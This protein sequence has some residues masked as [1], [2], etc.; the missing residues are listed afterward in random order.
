MKSLAVAVT[1]QMQA[2][3][4]RPVVL[5]EIGLSQTTLYYVADRVGITF[6]GIYYTPKAITLS[7]IGQS[8]EGQINRIDLNFD[9][10]NR[11][12]SAYA[13]YSTFD[14]KPLIIK[15][16]YRDAVSGTTHYNE[17]FHGT[18]EEIGNIASIWFPITASSGKAL[19]QRALLSEYQR[20]CRYIFGDVNCNISG[21]SDLTSASNYAKGQVLS[22]GTGHFI[23]NTA[24]GSVTGTNNDI[25][26]Y[27]TIKVGLSGT[28]Y[29]RTCTAWTSAT[30]KATWRVG[31]P[32][33]I[34]NSYAYEIYKGCPK[35][36]DAC[37]AAFAF[38][39]ISDNRINFGGFLH[40]GQDK[41]DKT[42]LS[43]K[44]ETPQIYTPPIVPR[45]DSGGSDDGP[46]DSGLISD[47]ERAESQDPGPNV[48]DVEQSDSDFGGYGG[49][50]DDRENVGM[51]TGTDTDHDPGMDSEGRDSG[52][53]GMG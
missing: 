2:Q 40:I 32:V 37:T 34:D 44:A 20:S 11:D 50:G 48:H 25:F 13:Q 5:F 10:V 15:R 45:D 33:S 29:N 23:I 8:S 30:S 43:G 38:G 21:F 7:S 1:T 42:E 6:A 4:K 18:M 24:V 36:L 14:G 16:V 51:D 49:F 27:G 26:K 9:N 19:Y 28:T 46:S 3:E 52:G 31:L 53:H 22:G 35:D 47:Q 39:P 17:I 41:Y 12:M